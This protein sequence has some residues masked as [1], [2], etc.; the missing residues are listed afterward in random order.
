MS[1]AVAVTPRVRIMVICD[2]VLESMI[3]PGFYDLEG[4]R[5]TM[6]TDAFPF[7][8]AQLWLFLLLSSPRAGSF[9]GYVRV[10]NERTDRV[11][12]YSHLNPRP[13]FDIDNDMFPIGSPIRCSFP[14]EGSYSVQVWFFQ[15]EGSDVL[16][17][18]MQFLIKSGGK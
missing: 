4:V 18:E 6:T 13:T 3:E 12:F 10:V 2:A 5:Q 9:P 7:V 1:A 11:V 14:E 15:A 8:P 16:K 17:G